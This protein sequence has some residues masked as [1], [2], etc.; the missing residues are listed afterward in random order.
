[1]NKLK[2]TVLMGLLLGMSYLNY[3]L[4]SNSEFIEFEKMDVEDIRGVIQQ[5]A[6]ETEGYLK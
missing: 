1:M 6:A 4:P 5:L 3:K 2:N